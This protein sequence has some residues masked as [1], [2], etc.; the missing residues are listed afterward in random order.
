AEAARAAERALEL[1]EDARDDWRLIELEVHADLAAARLLA[2]DFGG[3]ED[4]LSPLWSLPP[5]ERREGLTHRVRQAGALL[6]GNTYQDL[7]AAAS[8]GERIEDYAAASVVR[9]LPAGSGH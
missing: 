1:Y 6:A 2:G 4:A 5:H 3:A 7:R 8:L 9:A